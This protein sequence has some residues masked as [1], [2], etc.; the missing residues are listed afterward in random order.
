MDHFRVT[1]LYP[2][3]QTCISHL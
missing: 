2:Q 3:L 1:R